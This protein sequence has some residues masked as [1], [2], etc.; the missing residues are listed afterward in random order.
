M[1]QD[2]SIDMGDK[3]HEGK[4]V[5]RFR[6]MQGIKQDAFAG[7]LGNSWTQRKVSALEDKETID[8]DILPAVAHALQISPEVIKNFR[9]E[10]GLNIFSNTYNNSSHDHSTP[11]F[12]TSN[13]AS[14]FNPIEKWVEA[15]EENRKL[16]ERLLQAE[17]EKVALLE[18][19]FEDKKK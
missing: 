3:I 19:M 1:N 5:K 15:L 10:N 18:K 6:E 12:N 9:E 7:L 17:Q 16:Y 4:N 11:Q 8:R 13:H 2:N 14:T